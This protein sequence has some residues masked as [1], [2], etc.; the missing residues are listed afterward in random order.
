MPNPL[1]EKMQ[2]ELVAPAWTQALVPPILDRLRK[3]AAN[4]KE[5]GQSPKD[6]PATLADLI[7]L[8]EWVDGRTAP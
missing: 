4:G 5:Q 2:Q 8:V 6:I 1:P 3:R 7:E